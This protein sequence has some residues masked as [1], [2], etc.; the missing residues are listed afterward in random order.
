MLLLEMQNY[1]DLEPNSFDIILTNPPFGSLLS[2]ET[3]KGLAN[4]DLIEGRKSIPLETI[5]LE[6][7]IEFLRPGGKLG[8]VLPEGIF[9]NSNTKYVRKWLI[10]K[11][12]IV[13]IVS[14]PIETFSPFGANIKTSILIGGNGNQGRIAK[15]TMM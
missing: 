15:R 8:I 4:F 12:R 11:L 13:A 7:C 6:R 5:G 2:V 14:L 9:A 10:D 1:A 3:V